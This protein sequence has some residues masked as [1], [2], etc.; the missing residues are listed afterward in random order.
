[1]A[2]IIFLGNLFPVQEPVTLKEIYSFDWFN[3]EVNYFYPLNVI[4]AKGNIIEGIEAKT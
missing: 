2:A 1:M 4:I 3:F